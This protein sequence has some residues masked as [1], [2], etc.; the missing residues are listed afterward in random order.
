MSRFFVVMTV[1]AL[2][3]LGTG[4]AAAA[5]ARAGCGVAQAPTS[6]REQFGT[7]I[8]TVA[9]SMGASNVGNEVL[10]PVHEALKEGCPARQ[11]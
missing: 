11:R 9:R 5:E 8:G 4:A 3:T 6:V 10:Q 7:G 2:A 1:A